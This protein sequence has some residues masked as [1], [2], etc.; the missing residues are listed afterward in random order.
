MTFCPVANVAT[1]PFMFWRFLN[2]KTSREETSP[3]HA[4]VYFSA[5]F[6]LNNM[7]PKIYWPPGRLNLSKLEPPWLAWKAWYVTRTSASLNNEKILRKFGMKWNSNGSHSAAILQ[8]NIKYYWLCFF[9]W[10]IYVW[11]ENLLPLPRD[12]A[13]WQ[14]DS[15]AEVWR[16]SK[17]LWIMN[18][19]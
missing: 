6:V 18:G 13:L 16:N 15:A 12:F 8:G 1:W 10:A 2:T 5:S 7:L 17:Q 11:W 4:T 19:Q 14:T 3:D 9:N